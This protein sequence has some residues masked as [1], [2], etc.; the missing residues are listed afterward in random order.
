MTYSNPLA[1]IASI[2]APNT[3]IPVLIESDTAPTT[4]PSGDPLR[5]GDVWYNTLTFTENLYILTGTLNEPTWEPVGGRGYITAVSAATP[6]LPDSLPVATTITEGVIK[7]GDNLVISDAK[8]SVN[9]DLDVQN[10]TAHA[11]AT[12]HTIVTGADANGIAINASAGEITA[13]W[14]NVGSNTGVDVTDP[15]YDVGFRTPGRIVCGEITPTSVTGAGSVIANTVN[16]T[17]LSGAR[18]GLI[19]KLQAGDGLQFLD[20]G[21]HSY[22]GGTV[23]ND[24][25]TNTGTLAVG[26]TVLRTTGT[27]I[28]NGD[29]DLTATGAAT[30][31]VNLFTLKFKE[32]Y[33]NGTAAGTPTIGRLVLING[34]PN[35][36]NGAD[37]VSVDSGSSDYTLPVATAN[38][39]GGI[40][41]GSGL[42]IA[43]GGS[44]STDPAV[45]LDGGGTISSGNVILD[46]GYVRVDNA[47]GSDTA[48]EARVGT[49][50]NF[51]VLA[52]G[53]VAIGGT[54]DETTSQSNANIFL[55][56]T[57]ESTFKQT[58]KI[59]NPSSGN[60]A[61]QLGSGGLVQAT[62]GLTTGGTVGGTPN[63][64]ILA[65][66]SAE[67]AGAVKVAS[68][69]TGSNTYTMPSASGTLALTSDIASGITGATQT[70]GTFTA[71]LAGSTTNP[72]NAQSVTGNYVRI[73]DLVTVYIAFYGMN[74]TGAA[75][76]V[77]ITGLPFN[78]DNLSAGGNNEFTEAVGSVYF[79]KDELFDTTRTVNCIAVQ[80]T[81]T[82]QF[83]AQ[84]TQGFLPFKAS[85][86]TGMRL[87]FSLS[88]VT[89]TAV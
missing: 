11:G 10:I 71:T 25:N 43:S 20:N 47:T 81:S 29:I 56:N 48:F 41:V 78:V 44:L 1:T 88:Y 17:I 58:M 82:I 74:C 69:A 21:I 77:S 64:S 65:N 63:A 84:G 8:L 22:I 49:T 87:E 2:G 13:K 42:S 55:K 23:G 83:V 68:L 31:N 35:Y 33:A 9:T 66:G 73:G 72:T 60:T 28:I 86:S 53:G 36:G 50:L 76:T 38:D 57:G 59:V 32:N 61:I 79:D 37:W 7:V 85:P 30:G 67:F 34:V 89:D 46:S 16:V 12:L 5:P 27:Q 80:N 14:L 19:Y 45:L 62:G 70:K 24:Y 51:K 6:V 40:K 15:N 4:R 52:G 75:G 3:P 39:L 54:I 18:Q 26:P